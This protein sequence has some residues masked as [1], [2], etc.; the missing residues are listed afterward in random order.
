MRGSFAICCLTVLLSPGLAQVSPT[1]LCFALNG[2]VVTNGP[3]LPIDVGGT[4]TV[5]FVAPLTYYGVDEIVVSNETLAPYPT[6]VGLTIALHATT[7]PNAVGTLLAQGSTQVAT[8]NLADY[9]VVLNSSVSLTAA[10]QYA[11][12]LS[13]SVVGTNPASPLLI[14]T[15]STNPTL[16]PYQVT[17]GVPAAPQCALFSPPIGQAG[18][19]LKFRGY[20]C[21]SG[22]LAWAGLLGN[23]CGSNPFLTPVLTASGPPV[24]GTTITIVFGPS[25]LYPPSAQAV[26]GVFWS[27][28]SNPAGSP[29][30]GSPCLLYLDAASLTQL[31]AIGL[32]PAWSGI[33]ASPAWGSLPLAIPADPAL[34]GTV[35]AIQVVMAGPW[36]PPGP[37]LLNGTGAYVTKG[38]QLFIGY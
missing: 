15:E 8:G 36:A 9:A 27:L 37:L 26:A 29:I 5:F 6:V 11:V 17:C 38:L 34:V 28:G 32:E 3:A 33:I 12:V 21:G 31:N 4:T 13:A 19:R 24:I 18:V 23:A 2:A 30:P 22:Q 14:G 25:G 16:L 20:A 10:V 1:P 7:G 35:V